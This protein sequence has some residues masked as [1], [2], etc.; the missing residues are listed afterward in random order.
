MDFVKSPQMSAVAVV[1]GLACGQDVVAPPIDVPK[2]NG[3]G[4]K[5]RRHRSQISLVVSV[6]LKSVS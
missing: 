1:A 6:T 5:K 2:S 4:E 3:Q